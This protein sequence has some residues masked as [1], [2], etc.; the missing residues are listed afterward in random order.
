MRRE[1]DSRGRFI[2]S[3]GRS[4]TSR[5]P[6]VS[7]RSRAST[8]STQTHLPSFTDPGLLEDLRS[9]I[10]LKKPSTPSTEPAIEED[11]KTFVEDTNFST[12]I[13]ESTMAE[14]GGG[15]V[16]NGEHTL[17]G[18]GRGRGR[19]EGGRGEGGRGTEGGRGRIGSSFGFPILDEETNT[20][21]KN[22]SP[23]VLPN[24]YG[25][26][27][28]DPETFLFEFEVLC[29]TYDYLQDAQKLKLFPSTLKGAALKWFMS[30]NSSS[31]RTWEDMK[32]AF[33]E[34]YLDYCMP[35]N[36][37]EEVFKML[38]KEDENLED[39]LERFKY[40][41]KRAQM[42]NL[43][44]DTLKALLLKTIRDEWLDILNMMGKGDISQ[45]TLP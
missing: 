36:H 35:V 13:G 31:I 23:S 3:R 24:F 12:S 22:I 16:V 8:P 30:L 44:Q 17:F 25:I 11:P 34:R 45:L 43:D 27:T 37:K 10:P 26:R 19:G 15:G 20:T 38:Q 2:S 39:L 29:R 14:E 5:T 6:L 41:I 1:R 21:M 40:N 42:E 4:L 7:S 28:E 33:L 9:P 18:G 32:Q